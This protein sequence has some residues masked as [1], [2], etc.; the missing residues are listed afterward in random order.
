MEIKDEETGKKGE[1]YIEKDGDRIARIQ[2]FHSGEGVI[3]VYHTEVDEKLR[4]KGVGEKLVERVVKYTRD[5]G[6]KLVPKCP[7]ARKLIERNDELRSVL[8]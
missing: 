3:T 4:G 1:F 8:A 5:Q 2:Y 7:Y 6:L